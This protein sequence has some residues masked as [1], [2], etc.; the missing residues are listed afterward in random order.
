MLSVSS[1][2][3]VPCVSTGGQAVADQILHRDVDSPL[4]LS[5]LVNRDDVL[6]VKAGAGLRFA[7]RPISSCDAVETRPD[8][9]IAT[10]R[11]RWIGGL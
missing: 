1:N 3:S 11:S 6:V 2:G 10:V 4:N 8:R 9:L 5:H 7:R